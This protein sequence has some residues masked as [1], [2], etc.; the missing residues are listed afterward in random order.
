MFGHYSQAQ[1]HTFDVGL[2]FQKSVGLYYENGITGQ[3]NLTNRWAVGLTY[4]TSRLGTAWGT[5][6]IKQDN[7]FVSA[8]YKFRPA[9]ALQPFLRVN[10][11]YF[12]ADYESPI[13]ESLPH[14]SAIAS[15]DG[16][17]AYSFKF[18]I[19]INL[20]LGYNAF[21][22]NGESGAGTL[23]PVFYQLSVTYN[24]KCLAK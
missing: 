22:G 18:P 2:R 15:L 20:S 12:T 9:H 8:A 24:L 19:K 6:A 16:G 4:V 3:Y 7:I 13:F 17:L 10:L 21:T 1:V 23:Y 11:G 14:T 5:N